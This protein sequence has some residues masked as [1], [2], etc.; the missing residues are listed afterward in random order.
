MPNSIT[1]RPLVSSDAEAF[2]TWGGDPEVTRSLF[3]DH[4]S[5]VDE[6]RTFLANRA[7]KHPWFMAICLEGYP[8][9]AITLDRGSHGSAQRAEL[10]YVLARAHWGKGIATEASRQALARGFKEL[11]VIRIEATVDPENLGSVRVLEKAG[12]IRE[13]TLKSYVT[14]RGRVRDRYMYAAFA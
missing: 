11:G 9:G 14:H 10:G 8:V 1:L 3:W 6:A 2:M 5:S 13:A 7:E 4:Y 12:M